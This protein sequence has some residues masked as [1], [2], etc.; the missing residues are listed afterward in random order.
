MCLAKVK[1]PEDKGGLLV[2]IALL[3]VED[4][5][6]HYLARRGNWK[7]RLRRSIFKTRRFS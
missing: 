2:D 1:L 7:R 4:G 3:K 5:K 6:V